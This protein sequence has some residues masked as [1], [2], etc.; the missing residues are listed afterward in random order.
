MVLPRY[1]DVLDCLQPHA[2]LHSPEQNHENG[3]VSRDLSYRR[4]HY[5]AEYYPLSGDA[6]LT[7][8]TCCRTILAG[9]R[10]SF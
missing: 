2:Y 10:Y 5:Y 9:W 3:C 7:F 6:R 1:A 8:L 4:T